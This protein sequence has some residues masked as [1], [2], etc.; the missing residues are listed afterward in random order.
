MLQDLSDRT[1][2]SEKHVLILQRTYLFYRYDNDM[3]DANWREILKV[4][5]IFPHLVLFNF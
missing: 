1:V 5:L 2:F 3:S 4:Q